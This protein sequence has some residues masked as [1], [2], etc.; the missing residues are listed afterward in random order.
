MGRRKAPKQ[1]NS[2]GIGRARHKDQCVQMTDDYGEWQEMRLETGRQYTKEPAFHVKDYGFDSGTH[3]EQ[4]TVFVPFKILTL[5][6]R[7]NKYSFYLY[8]A[9]VLLCVIML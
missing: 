6:S 3:R 4:S 7:R 9:K 1:R 2:M 8:F 5:Q